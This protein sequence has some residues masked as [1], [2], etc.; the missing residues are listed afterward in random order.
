MIYVTVYIS[1]K[2]RISFKTSQEDECH[3]K[4]IKQNYDLKKKKKNNKNYMLLLH[5]YISIFFVD[6]FI[7]WVYHNTK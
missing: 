7:F 3:N 1:I 2:I 5:V 4:I 6:F